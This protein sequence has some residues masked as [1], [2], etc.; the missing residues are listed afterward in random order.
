MKGR[1][2]LCKGERYRDETINNLN[3]AGTIMTEYGT[4]DYSETPNIPATYVTPKD[5]LEIERYI[6]ATK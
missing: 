4:N 2:L 3:G 5:E 1:I 6:N